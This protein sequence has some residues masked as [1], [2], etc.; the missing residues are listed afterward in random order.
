MLTTRKDTSRRTLSKL[1]G[2]A[3][4][5]QTCVATFQGTDSCIPMAHLKNVPNPDWTCI[6]SGHMKVKISQN[7]SR[8]LWMTLLSH[9]I[10]T[11][12]V[13]VWC[14]AFDNDKTCPV[15]SDIYDPDNTWTLAKSTLKLSL[16]PLLVTQCDLNRFPILHFPSNVKQSTQE[17]LFLT[18]KDKRSLKLENLTLDQ[19]CF[20]R[21]TVIKRGKYKNLVKR[22][23]N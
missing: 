19:Q 8:Q 4:I 9:D 10:P 22:N 5:S 14:Q 12:P 21:R 2:K 23:P 7:W 6:S 13:N 3:P 1:S 15:T 17:M 16:L 11:R 20:Q 18:P